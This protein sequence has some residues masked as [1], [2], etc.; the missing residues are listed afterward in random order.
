MQCY[1]KVGRCLLHN[2]SVGSAYELHVMFS[3]SMKTLGSNAFRNCV[4]FDLNIFFYVK[5]NIDSDDLW[6]F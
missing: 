1:N 4:A 6:R 3:D 5:M 2:S